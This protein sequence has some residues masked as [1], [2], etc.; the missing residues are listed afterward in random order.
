MQ[1][2]L[3]SVNFKLVFCET[4]FIHWVWET[5]MLGL[6]RQCLVRYS[7]NF[8]KNNFHGTRD[9]KNYMFT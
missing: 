5:E 8:N 7:L 3:D 6:R 9:G 4:F 1:N 2:Y